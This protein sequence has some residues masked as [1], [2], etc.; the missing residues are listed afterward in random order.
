VWE[1]ESGESDEEPTP[2]P[3][4]SQKKVNADE[5]PENDVWGFEASAEKE[6]RKPTMLDTFVE[7]HQNQAEAETEIEQHESEMEITDP[8]ED[9]GS[10]Q[11]REL[12]SETILARSSPSHRETSL[13][14]DSIFD[15]DSMEE[16]VLESPNPQ[17]EHSSD[18]E[19]QIL[20][21]KGGP[22]TPP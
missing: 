13:A 18:D 20:S 15:V 16:G 19:L 7:R 14:Q 12:H 10:S 8:I 9:R 11:E 1:K 21:V 4:K 17:E 6:P 22:S 3:R 5:E 2:K